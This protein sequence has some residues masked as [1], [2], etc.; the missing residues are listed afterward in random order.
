[1]LR[2]LAGQRHDWLL[3]I[4]NADDPQ[5]NLQRFF[6]AWAHGNI[7]ITRNPAC[8]VYAPDSHVNV[9]GMNAND[10]VELL[11][12]M[13]TARHSPA[14]HQWARF[15]LSGTWISRSGS[16]SSQCIHWTF[17]LP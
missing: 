14:N 8:Q 11:L 13:S 12:K 10:A 4:D 1:V 7:I 3:L 5:I 6:P 17:L 15:D 9:S 2:L 16:C